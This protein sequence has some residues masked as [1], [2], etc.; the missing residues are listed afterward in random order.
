MLMLANKRTI[1]QTKLESLEKCLQGNLELK[2]PEGA[3]L[4]GPISGAHLIS[5]I[6][7]PASFELERIG[8]IR[9]EIIIRILILGLHSWRKES[10]AWKRVFG[11]EN[12]ERNKKQNVN[13]R[14]PSSFCS[15]RGAF[16]TELISKRWP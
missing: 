10:S 5:P 9:N 12:V 1:Q 7:W 13:K 16:S 6:N 8:R 2:K 4:M 3:D 11:T 14:W 15:M